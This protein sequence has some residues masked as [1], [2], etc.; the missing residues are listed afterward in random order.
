MV[1][2]AL[3]NTRAILEAA[4]EEN[5]GAPTSRL[6]PRFL[7]VADGAPAAMFWENLPAVSRNSSV[8]H[9]YSF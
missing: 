5:F 7:K 8:I 1:S 2:D 6:R 9:R 4:P 3:S